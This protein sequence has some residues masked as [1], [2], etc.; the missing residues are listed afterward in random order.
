MVLTEYDWWNQ[1]YHYTISKNMI[2]DYGQNPSICI[3]PMDLDFGQSK[4]AACF[5]YVVR[6]EVLVS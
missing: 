5:N 4:S 3:K 2:N 1:V 6:Q